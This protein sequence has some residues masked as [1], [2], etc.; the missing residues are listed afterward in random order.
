M[1]WK[2]PRTP[3]GKEQASKSLSQESREVAGVGAMDELRIGLESR[4]HC[5]MYPPASLKMQ[6]Q[7]L[8]IMNFKTAT[9]SI[10]PQVRGPP[11]C[12]MQLALVAICT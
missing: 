7:K 11:K 1:G 9:Q 4:L 2:G 6:V 8:I 12:R 5:Y 3:G 10:K